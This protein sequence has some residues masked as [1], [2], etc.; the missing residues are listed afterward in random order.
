MLVT[1]L[2]FS[3]FVTTHILAFLFSFINQLLLITQSVQHG[4]YLTESDASFFKYFIHVCFLRLVAI[5]TRGDSM[6]AKTIL[7]ELFRLSYFL[8]YNV[9]VLLKPMFKLQK[10]IFLII[11]TIASIE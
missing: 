8:M 10:E 3:L 7:Q 6:L 2:N 4:V 9:N 11:C 1:V 5:P